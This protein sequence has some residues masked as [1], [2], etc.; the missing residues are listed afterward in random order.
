MSTLIPFCSVSWADNF[1]IGHR[2]ADEWT[3]ANIDE[4]SEALV[5]A[6][7][8]I[9]N[10]CQFFDNN[11]NIITYHPNNEDDDSIPE[12]LKEACCY[13]ALYFL[14]LENDPARPFPLGIL[15]LI[16]SGQET[17]SH[18]YEPPLFPDLVR[19]IIEEN[20]GVLNDPNYNKN[21]WAVKYML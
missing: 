20:G 6:T 12:W 15:G 4:R 13:E 2:W 10:F 17:F 7:S 3:S 18:D 9:H 5:S 11:L 19:R 16:K 14:H 1:I 8:V 21:A